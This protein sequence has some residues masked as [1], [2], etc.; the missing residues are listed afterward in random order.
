MDSIVKR[1]CD[2]IFGKLSDM[3]SRIIDSENEDLKNRCLSPTSPT[4]DEF[5]THVQDNNLIKS[6]L[7]S[8][9]LLKFSVDRL[10]S[11]DR[12]KDCDDDQLQNKL[13]C[14]RSNYNQLAYNYPNTLFLNANPPV[15]K[16]PGEEFGITGSDYFSQKS[17]LRPMP[18]RIERGETMRT[19]KTDY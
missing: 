19:N 16:R 1:N 14:G 4:S 9:K 15:I 8:N 10:L 3:E 5:K 2:N 11:D 13:C 12:K 18:I 7:S 6:P 17:I